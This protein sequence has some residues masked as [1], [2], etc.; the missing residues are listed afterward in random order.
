MGTA[1]TSC[2]KSPPDLTLK[3]CAK[4]SATPYCSRECQKA[5]WKA[6]KKICGKQAG[7]PSAIPVEPAS[8][9]KVSPPKG[10]EKGVADPFTR[11]DKG[12][13]LHDRPEKDVYALLID[14]YRL[15]VDDT[16][17]MDGEVES[18]SVY[19][20]A[21]DGLKGFRR[22]IARAAAQ[23]GLLP[24]WWD[25][26]KKA[27]CEALGMKAGEWHDLR[28]A[29]EKHDIIDRYGDARFPMQLR[30]FAEAVNGRGPG[31]SNGAAMRRMMVAMEQGAEGDMVA[32]TM[33]MSGLFGRR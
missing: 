9:G 10:L 20:G 32:S 2:N 12:V 11:L 24:P 19:S 6:H 1:C 28:C 16:Y 22:F 26:A 17:K 21:A 14:A 25:D 30:M 13:W 7:G 4:C 23:P 3:K 33:D 18:D 5:D 29:V 8:A 27:D 15:H 31:G